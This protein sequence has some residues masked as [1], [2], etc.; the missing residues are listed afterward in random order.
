[1]NTKNVQKESFKN[2]MTLAVVFVLGAALVAWL[3]LISGPREKLATEKSKLDS[4][5]KSIAQT[6]LPVTATPASIQNSKA[7]NAKTSVANI[8]SRLAI[9][10]ASQGVT[11]SLTPGEPGK[12]IIN[13]QGTP[14]KTGKFLQTFLSNVSF[15]TDGQI[16]NK[17]GVP[18]IKASKIT[19]GAT[20]GMLEVKTK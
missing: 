19:I 4:L 18:I 1:M 20:E 10:A 2:D 3:L 7:A 16:Q 8:K 5:E 9:A 11:Y 12:L 17:G 14:V 13:F 6:K 15:S